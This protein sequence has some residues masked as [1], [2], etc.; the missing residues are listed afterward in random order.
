MI[1]CEECLKHRTMN[2]YNNIF[3]FDESRVV[4][5]DGL[6]ADYINANYVNGYQRNRAYIMTQVGFW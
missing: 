1:P 2:R 5:S 6:G 4:L 3:C